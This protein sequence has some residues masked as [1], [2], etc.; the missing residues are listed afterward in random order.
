MHENRTHSH[1]GTI[2]YSLRYFHLFT[3]YTTYPQS[4]YPRVFPTL[5]VVRLPEAGGGVQ[6][7]G[8]QL[9]GPEQLLRPG[10]Q[11][12]RQAAGLQ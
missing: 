7:T 9:G 10:R 8:R 1:Y 4:Y 6:A 3:F 2:L 5:V 12:P 11:A